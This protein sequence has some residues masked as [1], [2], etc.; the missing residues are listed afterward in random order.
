LGTLQTFLFSS[1]VFVFLSPPPQPN[2]PLNPPSLPHAPPR[3]ARNLQ[4]VVAFTVQWCALCRGYEAEFTRVAET[5]A[6]LIDTKRSGQPLVFA[7]VDVDDNRELAKT[8][9]VTS[10]PFVAVLKHKRWYTVSKGGT[11]IRQPKRYQ[12]Y[13]G[14]SPTVEWLNRETGMKADMRPYVYDL[15]D[16]TVEAFVNDARYDVLVEFY[17]PWCGHCKQF[18]PFYFEVGAHFAPDENVRIARIDVDTHR[19]AAQLY[20][21]TGLPSLQLFPKGYKVKG[22]HF[23]GS[24]RKPAD[25]ITFVKSPQVRAV[26]PGGV[27]DWLRTRVM[28]SL[29]ALPRRNLPLH[30]PH[31]LSSIEC[32]LTHNH[33]VVKVAN[34]TPGC[35]WWRRR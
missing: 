4:V 20:N 12:G 10:A 18:A 27:S 28:G 26:T 25:I 6:G 17:A 1:N 7:R 2:N 21:V 22:L 34:P 23:K 13:L 11:A 31:W 30:R 15:T 33:N 19:D 24:E 32:V 35:I 16:A 9:G 14:A 5:Y 3:T 8:F 29:R